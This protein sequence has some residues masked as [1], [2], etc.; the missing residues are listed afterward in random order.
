MQSFNHGRRASIG[1]FTR[2]SVE[3]HGGPNLVQ[4]NT[5]DCSVSSVQGV[6]VLPALHERPHLHV[7]A[8]P[9]Y[10]PQALGRLC[11]QKRHE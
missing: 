4:P 8:T 10:Q 1:V 11:S 2:R 3:V 5:T 9:G 7:Q 6:L